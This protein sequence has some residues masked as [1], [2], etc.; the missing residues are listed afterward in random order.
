M[1][2]LAITI[3]EEVEKDDSNYQTKKRELTRWMWLSGYIN[4]HVFKWICPDNSW[5]LFGF[6]FRQKRC[7]LLSSTTF[8]SQ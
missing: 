1:K 6:P 4:L 8:T 7:Y 5:F 2:L 3:W